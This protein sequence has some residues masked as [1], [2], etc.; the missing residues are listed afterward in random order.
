MSYR[1]VNRF[2]FGT[3][4][5]DPKTEL[6]KFQKHVTD[7]TRHEAFA[8]EELGR[9]LAL[10]KA[11]K[12]G[13]QKA[14]DSLEPE[15]YKSEM[16]RF[17]I[18]YSFSQFRQIKK[19]AQNLFWAILQ[20]YDLPPR[21]RKGIEAASRFWSKEKVVIRRKLR[22]IRYG[23]DAAYILKYIETCYEIRRQVTHA[24]AAIV[25]GKLHS[26]PEVAK[27]SK[28]KI[29]SFTL[30]NTG[31]FDDETMA[32]A[33]NVVAK[34]ER[35]M[36]QIGLGRVCYGDIYISKTIDNKRTIA[37]FYLKA[38]DEMF[39]RANTPV[40]WDTVRVICH[41][42]A[43]RLEDRFLQEKDI[44]GIYRIIKTEE[45]V[46]DIPEELMPKLNETL[47]DKGK[48]LTVVRIDKYR[49]KVIWKKEGDRPGALY[50]AP[51]EI[52]L[53]K[54]GIE[55]H[56]RP[57]YKGFITPY[58]KSNPSENFAEMVSYYAIGK[59]PQAQIELLE[60]VIKL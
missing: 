40:D 25:Q 47:E 14:I 55:P 20:Q 13:D 51:I 17:E 22:D 2:L 46:K 38:S 58:A 15:L 36:H 41:E 33:A 12:Q 3:I 49:N 50:T 32:K 4:I 59:L 30:I 42:L 26:D 9:I 16:K 8:K 11:L 24:Q 6:E 7:F 34:A 45:I 18:R 28:I 1:I 35:S 44:I 48:T 23:T 57:E 60:S 52:W 43:H 29:G 54:K 53:R 56:L 10:D 19:T 31:G 21:I 5:A 37:A 39:V 27:K